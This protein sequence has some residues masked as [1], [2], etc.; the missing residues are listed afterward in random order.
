M[1]VKR[2]QFYL[3]GPTSTHPAKYGK[4]TPIGAGRSAERRNFFA[5][6]R[7]P[8]RLDRKL[9]NLLHPRRSVR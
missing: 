6:A 3:N 4:A 2:L 5:W 7:S 8:F 1:R 9:G